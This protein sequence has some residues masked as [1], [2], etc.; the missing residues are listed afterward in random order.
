MRIH[1]YH[2]NKSTTQMSFFYGVAGNNLSAGIAEKGK[3]DD[4][5]EF[6]RFVAWR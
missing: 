5:E 1:V 2:N 3:D 6:P 4:D